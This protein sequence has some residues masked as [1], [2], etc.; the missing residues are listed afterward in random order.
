MA[1]LVL[2]A[3]SI[4]PVFKDV[5]QSKLK[6]RDYLIHC[7]FQTGSR[8]QVSLPFNT[9]RCSHNVD[10]PYQRSNSSKF[11]SNFSSNDMFLLYPFQW[12]RLA[13]VFR[14]RRTL[15]PKWHRFQAREI[16]R[17]IPLSPLTQMI[18]TFS[19]MAPLHPLMRG[20]EWISRGRTTLG[21]GR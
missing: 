21:R 4:S 19:S 8:S 9:R 16:R 3:L 15:V 10:I 11:Y 7:V 13:S 2:T 14:Q 12:K 17:S 18:Q 1:A 20:L 5:D 6:H